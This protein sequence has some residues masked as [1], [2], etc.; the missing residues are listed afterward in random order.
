MWKRIAGGLAV[1][2]SDAETAGV[3][4]ALRCEDGVHVTGVRAETDAALRAF[5]VGIDAVGGADG[6]YILAEQDN[7]FY[8]SLAALV[9]AVGAAAPTAHGPAFDCG[10]PD[11]L[12]APG[13]DWHDADAARPLLAAAARATRGATAAAA[14][15]LARCCRPGRIESGP[16][17]LTVDAVADRR[18]PPLLRALLARCSSGADGGGEGAAAAADLLARDA[19]WPEGA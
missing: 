19:F 12:H 17:A 3:D 15:A 11:G 8:C 16:D 10:L 5:L 4:A 14:H 7:G 18:V 13:W 6:T 9:A 1:H 2:V